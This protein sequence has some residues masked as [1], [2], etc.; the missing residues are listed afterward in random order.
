LKEELQK[1]EEEKERES[2]ELIEMWI[3]DEIRETR[4]FR[5]ELE[6]KYYSPSNPWD[7]PGMSIRD[8]I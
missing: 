1:T 6:E 2:E 7:A 4:E 3:E 8:F 5:M